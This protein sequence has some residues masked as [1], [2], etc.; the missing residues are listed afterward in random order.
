MTN[1]KLFQDKKIRSVWNDEEEQWY[2]SVVDVV[3]ALTD[4]INPTDYLKKM[5]KRDEALGVYLGTNC[6]QV[7]M[8][9]ET[10]KKRKTLA[11]NVKSLF[12]IIQSIPSPKAEP[13]KQWLA[14]PEK[15]LKRNLVVVFRTPIIIY[16]H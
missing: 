6:P 14:W 5:R 12:R 7:D 11:A 2:F 1:I 3:A 10:G 9:T 8:L 4:S 16:P 13:F 15:R